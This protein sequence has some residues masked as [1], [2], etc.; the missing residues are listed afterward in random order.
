MKVKIKTWK[1]MKKEF[2]LD[3]GGDINCPIA[4]TTIMEL[5]MPKDRIIEVLLGMYEHYEY[6]RKWFIDE[7]IIKE[8]L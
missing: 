5:L 7:N 4:F 2:G 3:D 1:E 8:K 6:N